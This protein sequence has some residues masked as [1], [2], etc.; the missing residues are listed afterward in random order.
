MAWTK[1]DKAEADTGFLEGSG[2]LGNGFL[3]AENTWTKLDKQTDEVLGYGLDM[4]GIDPYGSPE[5]GSMWTKLTKAT[6]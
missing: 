5:G 4:W 6:P 2:F 3:Q 1:I